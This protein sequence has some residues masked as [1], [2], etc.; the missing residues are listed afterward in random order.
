LSGEVSC[1]L[2]E[3]YQLVSQS[4][5]SHVVFEG[6]F[7]GETV[8]EFSQTLGRL[9][10]VWA[11]KI[12][13]LGVC[14][15][16]DSASLECCIDRLNPQPTPAYWQRDIRGNKSSNLDAKVDAALI[17]WR[18]TN[19]RRIAIRCALQAR[20]HRQQRVAVLDCDFA[21]EQVPLRILGKNATVCRRIIILY[22]QIVVLPGRGDV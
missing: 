2:T 11:V 21:L 8:V 15:R 5:A 1:L 13:R 20:G 12:T 19:S 3:R 17:T 22:P 18:S 14:F 9:P 7:G 10:P 16:A 4:I 6:D